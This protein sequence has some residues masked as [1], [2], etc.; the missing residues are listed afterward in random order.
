MIFMYSK[1]AWKFGTQKKSNPFLNLIF[2]IMLESSSRFFSG[3]L[4]LLIFEK[5]YSQNWIKS[6]ELI[7]EDLL[8]KINGFYSNFRQNIV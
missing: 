5:S 6:T 2:I 4:T 7:I 3:A 8:L 1:A